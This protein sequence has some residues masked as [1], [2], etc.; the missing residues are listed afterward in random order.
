MKTSFLRFLALALA[1]AALGAVAGAAATRSAAQPDTASGRSVVDWNRLLLSIV[2][3]PG[4]Q[5][6]T[7]QPTRN[8]AI[9]HAAIYDAVDSIDRSHEPY[10]IAVRAPR[11]ASET[12]AADAA[13]R[14]ALVGLYPTQ[15]SA[16]DAAYASE[17]AGVPN[18]KAKE[19]GVRV[20]IEVANDLLAIRAN[21]GSATTPPPS[22]STLRSGWA[23]SRWPSAPRRRSAS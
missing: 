8:F 17:I 3:T 4:A 5:P 2:N 6:A 13:A 21:D 16:I 12:A 18:G 19:W 10:L 15:Q 22:A 7:I 1:I 20:G 23:R 11:S 14:T 9:L